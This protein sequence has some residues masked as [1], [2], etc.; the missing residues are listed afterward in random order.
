MMTKA[1]KFC[2]KWTQHLENISGTLH[3]LRQNIEFTDV[4]LACEDQQMLCHKVILSAS[5]PVLRSLLHQGHHQNIL[6]YLRGVQ[7]R[8]LAAIL[9]FIY[10]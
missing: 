2:L 8:Q 4:T 6:L 7:A 9:D 1:D 3:D 5:S 10:R